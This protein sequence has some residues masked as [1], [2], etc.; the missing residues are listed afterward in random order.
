[1]IINIDLENSKIDTKNFMTTVEY[2][3]KSIKYAQKIQNLVPM[4]SKICNE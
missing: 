2:C 3:L 4:E 1:M